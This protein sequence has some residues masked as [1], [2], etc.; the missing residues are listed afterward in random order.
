MYKQLKIQK[1]LILIPIGIYT[2]PDHRS[3]FLKVRSDHRLIWQI[4]YRWTDAIEAEPPSTSLL[5][6]SVDNTRW[7][8]GTPPILPPA[9]PAPRR[10]IWRTWVLPSPASVRPAV[11]ESD[12]RRVLIGWDLSSRYRRSSRRNWSRGSRGRTAPGS[13]R[14]RCPRR[15]CKS[16]ACGAWSCSL[17]NRRSSPPC[18]R[19]PKDLRVWCLCGWSC[20]YGGNWGRSAPDRRRQRDPLP[21]KCL[22]FPGGFLRY[23]RPCTPLKSRCHRRASGRCRDTGPQTA[24]P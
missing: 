4:V 14:R 3:R 11:R 8:S 16:R 9:A 2:T 17:R 24:S 10:S 18:S 21:R 12:R 22:W 15:S 19:S 13:C 20:G 7:S 5:N 23:R 6:P 1:I